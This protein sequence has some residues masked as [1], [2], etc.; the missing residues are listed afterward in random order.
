MAKWKLT[1][2]SIKNDLRV[3]IGSKETVSVY[4]LSTFFNNNHKESVL[5]YERETKDFL[6]ASRTRLQYAILRVNGTYIFVN[7]CIA[8]T[9]WSSAPTLWI[10]NSKTLKDY[11]TI[12]ESMV[13]VSNTFIDIKLYNVPMIRY[14]SAL[15]L[16]KIFNLKKRF[17]W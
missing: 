1:L 16:M 12:F 2:G 15:C 10:F 13:P 3:I 14:Y 7:R 11:T 8:E 5:L 9:S 17:L 4:E 6:L